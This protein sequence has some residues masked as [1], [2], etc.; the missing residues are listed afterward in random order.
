MAR[1]LTTPRQWRV[2]RKSVTQACCTHPTALISGVHAVG[3][4]VS[5][6]NCALQGY[7]CRYVRVVVWGRAL[8]CIH[9]NVLRL[10]HLAC[11]LNVTA[12]R[13]ALNACIALQ[14]MRAT[15]LWP[16]S[17]RAGTCGCATALT[18]AAFNSNL[19]AKRKSAKKLEGTR[20]AVLTRIIWGL[21][22]MHL[23]H[24]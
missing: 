8:I 13:A 23:A 7:V 18:H 6:G 17:L 1:L 19:T 22:H 10:I 24:I 14:W 12:R 20:N 9:P 3:R 2:W 21:A 5:R 11:W 16:L 15:Q 4:S